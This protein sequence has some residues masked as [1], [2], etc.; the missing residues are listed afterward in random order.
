MLSIVSSIKSKVDRGR[1]SILIKPIDSKSGY[2]H[3]TMQSVQM[4]AF[5]FFSSGVQNNGA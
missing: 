1:K 4:F 2:S 3:P 5:A